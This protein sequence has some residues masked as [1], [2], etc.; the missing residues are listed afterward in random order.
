MFL[1]P[2]VGIREEEVAVTSSLAATAA[3]EMPTPTEPETPPSER[4]G[5]NPDSVT[6]WLWPR[7]GVFAVGKDVWPSGHPREI[8][9]GRGLT[10]SNIPCPPR[11]GTD[12]GP[13]GSLGQDSSHLTVS[14]LTP[15]EW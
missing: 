10:G 5:G 11:E 6:T 2:K 1:S 15:T 7:T 14:S 13:A 8:P 3:A 9:A 12:S 4:A